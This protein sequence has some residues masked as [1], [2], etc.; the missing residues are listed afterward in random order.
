MATSPGH[1]RPNEDFVGAVP[2][3][4][5]LIDGAGIPGTEAICHH[6]VAWYSHTLGT[7]LLGLLSRQP[8][9]DLAPALAEA[10]SRVADLHRETCDLANPSSPQATVAAVRFHADRV[11]HLVLADAF[12]VL[13]PPESG[14]QVVTDPRE[15]DVRDE[16]ASALRGLAPGSPEYERVLPAV[17]TAIRARRNQPGGYWV[18]K[19]D[20]RAATEAVTGS[21]AVA[22]LTGAAVLSNGASRFVDPYRLGEWRDVVDLLRAKGPDEIVR[23]V[24]AAEGSGSDIY[25]PDD[26]SVAYARVT[27]P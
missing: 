9:L 4:V 5:V 25:S 24:R 26:A 3:A 12:V 1:G 18:A 2:G 8:D 19:D 23:R 16:C 22:S 10:I 17:I 13:D 14:P 11:E 27:P 21:T 15:V 20:P 7:T 6:G